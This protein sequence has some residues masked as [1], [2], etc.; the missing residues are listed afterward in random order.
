[1]PKR[2]PPRSAQ[3]SAERAQ[4][5]E[6]AGS[7]FVDKAEAYR[8]YVQEGLDDVAAGRLHAWADVKAEM[9]AK[10]GLKKP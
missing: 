6:D 5:V 1:M 9:R 8:L 3:A 10:Y 7:E 2:A 4:G